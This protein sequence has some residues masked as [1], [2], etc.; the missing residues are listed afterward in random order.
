MGSEDEAE[1]SKWRPYRRQV[2]AD[3]RT[4]LIRRPARDISPRLVEP[5]VTSY[6]IGPERSSRCSSFSGPSELAAIS[7]D[8]MHNHG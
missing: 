2:Q 1:Q 7:P 3:M 6:R 4:H 8:A 5:R